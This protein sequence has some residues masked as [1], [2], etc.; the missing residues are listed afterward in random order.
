M[1]TTYLA[2]TTAYGFQRGWSGK[3]I[4]VRPLRCD[5]STPLYTHRFCNGC[6]VAVIMPFV[7]PLSITY[8]TQRLEKKIRKIELTDDDWDW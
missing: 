4:I 2:C 5:A 8:A 1:M 6:L 3:N 7:S